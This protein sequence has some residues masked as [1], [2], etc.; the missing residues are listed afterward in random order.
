MKQEIGITRPEYLVEDWPGKYEVFSWLE[1]IVT[2]PN[3][4]FFITTRKPNGSP[5]AN[6]SS[7]G[8]LIGEKDNY[9]S[10]I[11]LLN[12]SHTY[13]N[14]LREGEWCVCFPTFRHYRQCF[15]TIR[16][17]AQDNDEISDSGFTVELPVSVKAPRI[18][19]CPINLECRLAWHHPLY[20]NSRWHL[21]AGRVLH[22]AMDESVMV[23][24]PVERMRIMELMYNIRSTVHPMTGEQ[25]GPNTLGLLS[26]VEDIFGK[27]TH[28]KD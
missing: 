13:Q 22:L 8:F 24:D 3:P 11:A 2:V 14:I 4:I 27:Q 10:V 6:L 1:Y 17:N 28:R 7:W 26:R 19:E 23:P 21:F 5:N 12:D 18:S 16:L 15:E 25:Y 9:S 20:D